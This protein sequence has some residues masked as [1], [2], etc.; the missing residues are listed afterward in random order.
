MPGTPTI[1]CQLATFTRN[2]LQPSPNLYPLR[3]LRPSKPSTAD[4]VVDLSHAACTSRI[5][6]WIPISRMVSLSIFT[7]T[8]HELL[9]TRFLS[10]TPSQTLRRYPHSCSYVGQSNALVSVVVCA[11]LLFMR[12][13]PS[14]LRVP[15]SGSPS[16]MLD[17]NQDLLTPPSS[18]RP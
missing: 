4:L 3:P 7:F 16:D 17:Y 15:A 10:R 2:K 5:S 12:L 13:L 1:N 11:M 8:F 18:L 9:P 6:G 14:G